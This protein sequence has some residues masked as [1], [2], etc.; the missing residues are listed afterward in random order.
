MRKLIEVVAGLLMLISC[1]ITRPCHQKEETIVNIKDSIAWHDSTIFTYL[2]K[3][4]YVDT[5]YRGL[6]G[7]I[8]N[9]SDVPVKTQ[10]KWKERIIYRDSIKTVEKGVPVE[11]IKEIKVYP[12]TYWWFMAISIAALVYIILKVYLKFKKI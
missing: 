8:E 2:T 4:R 5:T 11:V 9:K 6:K 12:K 1:G 10:I 7:T 3:E